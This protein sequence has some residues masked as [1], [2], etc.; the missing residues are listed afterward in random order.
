MTLIRAQLGSLTVGDG[1]PVII[2]A[3]INRDPQSFFHKSFFRAENQALKAIEHMIEDGAKIIDVGGASTAPGTVTVSAGMEEKRV[4][5]LIKK[6]AN[7]WDIPISIDTQRSVVA[8]KALSVG[9]S[10]VNDVSGLKSDTIMA[11]EIRN[12][13]ASCILMACEQQPGDCRT[14]KHINEALTHSIQLASIAEIPL[15]HI[16]ID[17]GVG[18]GKPPECDLVILRDLH[19]LRKLGCPILI[20]L[21]RKAFI[22]SILGYSSPN[23]RLSGTLAAVTIA[24]LN[25]AHIIR[26]HDVRET[27]DCVKLVNAIQ[28]DMGCE[29]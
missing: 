10:I 22:G 5:S 25:G 18:F 17:P 14:I 2:M 3:V 24:A 26:A 13:G 19:M 12:A 21:S 9:A 8:R 11:K 15:D 1:T 27:R 7:N 20:G 28:S 6:I 23:D 16:T 29:S 4:V